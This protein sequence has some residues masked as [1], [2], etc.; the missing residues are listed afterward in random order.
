VSCKVA[1]VEPFGYLRDV[2]ERVCT[3]PASRVE[4]LIPRH[5][6]ELSKE[7]ALESLDR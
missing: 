2:L 7:G 3:H 4:E 1:R 6:R 5:W